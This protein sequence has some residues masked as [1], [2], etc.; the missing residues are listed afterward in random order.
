MALNKYKKRY[1]SFEDDDMD[2]NDD[3][4]DEDEEVAHGESAWRRSDGLLGKYIGV[5]LEL[6]AADEDNWNVIVDAMPEH[7]EGEDGPAPDFEEDGSLDEYSGVE[8]IFPPMKPSAIRSRRSYFNRSIRAIHDAGVAV[9]TYACGMHMNVNAW[10]WNRIKKALFS[11]M[12]NRMPKAHL[13][14]LGGRKLNGYCM[15]YRGHTWPNMRSYATY[16]DNEHAHA[17]EDKG[18]RLECRFPAATTDIRVIARL[19]YFLEF[20][21]DFCEENATEDWKE[22]LQSYANLYET[23]LTWLRNKDNTHAKSLAD[24]L[25]QE[26]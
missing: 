20:L 15:Q 26:G 22:R 9:P 2:W 8:I 12:I 17:C 25:T 14:K 7:I 24:F 11:A 6:E 5:E 21:E 19:S 4:E 23:F 16:P 10:Q 13:E 18:N 3:F 1:H